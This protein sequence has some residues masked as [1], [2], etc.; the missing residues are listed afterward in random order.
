MMSPVSAGRQLR[1]CYLFDYPLDYFSGVP[2]VC[3]FFFSAFFR[4]FS[5][6]FSHD[7]CLRGEA[8][9][10]GD[11]CSRGDDRLG[12]NSRRWKADFPSPW[13]R[14]VGSCFRFDGEPMGGGRGG[15]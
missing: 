6:A 15:E 4:N 8:C 11:E 7:A 14:L 2:L 3:S 1:V 13:C 12:L 5:G 10:R 9:S